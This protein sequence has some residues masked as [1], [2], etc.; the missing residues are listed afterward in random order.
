MTATKPRSN[1]IVLD[2]D[3][4]VLD[5]LAQWEFVIEYHL[6]MPAVIKSHV[7]HLGERYGLTDKQFQSAWNYFDAAGHWLKIPERANSVTHIKSILGLGYEVMLLTAARPSL[8]PSRI[9]NLKAIGMPAAVQ[10][11]ST[12]GSKCAALSALQPF[13]FVD[14]HDAHLQEAVDAAVPIIIQIPNSAKDSKSVH[15]HHHVDDLSFVVELLK[16]QHQHQHIN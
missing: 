2:I 14:D 8:E 13:I 11:T 16:T 3:G 6:K 15:A 12:G 9:L 7:Y 5:Y 1:L 10:I 4:V